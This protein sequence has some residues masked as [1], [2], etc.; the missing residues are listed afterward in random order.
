V[1]SSAYRAVKEV[2]GH[3]FVDFFP[4]LISAKGGHPNGGFNSETKGVAGIVAVKVG[5]KTVDVF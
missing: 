1:Y 3:I 4:A 2:L 5:F